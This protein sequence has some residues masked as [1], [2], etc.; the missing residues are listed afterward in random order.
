[1]IGAPN[2]GIAAELPAVVAGGMAR[3]TTSSIV[4]DGVVLPSCTS[5]QYTGDAGTISVQTGPTGYLQWAIYMHDPS[6]DAG[7]WWVD[8]FVGKRRVDHKE[9]PGQV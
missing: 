7:A 5:L 2:A 8:V 9:P 1:M 3:T 6:E 4:L